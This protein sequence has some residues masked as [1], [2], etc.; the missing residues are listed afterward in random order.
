MKKL[1]ITINSINI[2]VYPCLY[3]N[4]CRYNLNQKDDTYD[5]SDIN[6]KS[7]YLVAGDSWKD[8]EDSINHSFHNYSDY[9]TRFNED[10]YIDNFDSLVNKDG[11]LKGGV[12][13]KIEIIKDNIPFYGISDEMYV[14]Y[15]ELKPQNLGDNYFFYAGSNIEYYLE[16]I[17]FSLA[18]I[19]IVYNN[20]LDVLETD[21]TIKYD[22][23]N[24]EDGGVI[25]NTIFDVSLKDKPIYLKGSIK[26]KFSTKLE[27]IG[28]RYYF[29]KY[30]DLAH[31]F[32][33]FPT[34]ETEIIKFI[35]N[36]ISNNNIYYKYK[37]DYDVFFEYE[38]FEG[39]KFSLESI[40]ISALESSKFLTG[41]YTIKRS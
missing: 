33:K 23:N 9:K 8:V 19:R 4:G 12:T 24:I 15:Y 26:T 28:T 39:A 36:K 2:L 10:W 41:S 34:N 25:A 18:P 38:T 17:T 37:K 16:G 11:F 14:D 40:T 5:I 31:Y 1:L 35:N 3:L 22:E 13:F 32:S 21:L 27:D 30:K 6:F 7:I 20:Y 29:P